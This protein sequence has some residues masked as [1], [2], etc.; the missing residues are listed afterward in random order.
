MGRTVTENR[1][2]IVLITVIKE[3]PEAGA[4]ATP[5][6]EFDDK[7]ALLNE[8]SLYLRVGPKWWAIS[9]TY[10]QVGK[11]SVTHK[12]TANWNGI[13]LPI[14][15][16]EDLTSTVGVISQEMD[17]LKAQNEVQDADPVSGTTIGIVIGALMA[18]G[19]VIFVVSY[20]CYKCTCFQ[21]L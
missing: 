20:L 21:S 4:A 8:R 17:L 18:I 9:G 2:G 7:I 3:I 12:F 1:A 15:D 6:V 5:I 13:S 19:C 11:G 10:Q 16:P 14:S